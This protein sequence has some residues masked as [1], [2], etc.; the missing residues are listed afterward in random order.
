MEA[1]NQLLKGHQK[2]DQRKEEGR[3][4]PA[5]QKNRIEIILEGVE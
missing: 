2:S 4:A 1:P 3:T 5:I